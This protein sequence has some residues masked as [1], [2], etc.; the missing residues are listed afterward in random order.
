[1][2]LFQTNFNRLK[3]AMQ[4]ALSPVIKENKMLLNLTKTRI[5]Y[6][7]RYISTTSARWQGGE[8]VKKRDDHDVI[9]AIEK[10]P[11]REPLVKNFF[12]YKVDTELMAYPE[13]I[14]QNDHLEIVNRRKQ[15][16]GEFLSTNIF[17]NPD[18]VNNIRKLKEFGAFHP[19]PP[20]VTESIYGYR[21][22]ES[23]YLSYSTFLDN[24]QQVLKLLNEFGDET[25]K[26]KYLSKLES[27]ELTAIPCVFEAN[28]DIDGKKTFLTEAV[29]KDGTD[30]WILNGEKNFL[31]ISPA[32][33]DSTA[34]L[35]IAAVEK[36][37]RKGDFEEGMAAIF[38]D[39]SLPGV[40]ISGVDQTI[41]Y[42]EKVFN[43]VSVKFDNVSLK[44]CKQLKLFC[45][46][47]MLK[48]YFCS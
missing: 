1:M 5:N 38:V 37:D 14:F 20:L 41:G 19:H 11:Q 33:K 22:P 28:H 16:Y 12:V 48:N 35:V 2:F 25:L 18:D 29:Y 40:S 8:L 26:L 31:L 43:Q 47:I 3:V 45:I 4:R 44:P 27:G 36:T 23:Q 21:E 24:H 32:F 30:E 17:E 10:K 46:S 42:D 9:G 13:A 15:Q 34:F 7:C 6:A 39:G